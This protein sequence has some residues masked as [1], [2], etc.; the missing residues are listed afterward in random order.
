MSAEQLMK[1]AIELSLHGQSLTYPNPIVGALI[2]DA[3]G[4]VI[5]Q[6]FHQGAEHAEVLAINNAKSIPADATLFV[7]LEPCNHFGKTPPCTDAIL[8]PE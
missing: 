8:N 3:N 6:A 7:T 2:A 4:D 1:H 5:S